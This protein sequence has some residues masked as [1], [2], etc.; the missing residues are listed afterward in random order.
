MCLFTDCS[1]GI[2]TFKSSKEWINHEFQ[3]HRFTSQWEC[4]LCKRT[5]KFDSPVGLQS[6]LAHS[7]PRSVQPSELNE[8][9]SMSK[10][11]TPRDANMERCPF[12]DSFQAQNRNQ[13]QNHVGGHLLKVSLACIPSTDQDE[14]DES[15]SSHSSLESDSQ[16]SSP[17]DSSRPSKPTTETVERWL[18]NQ[19]FQS[20][21]E[22][23]PGSNNHFLPCDILEGRLLRRF[24]VRMFL[25]AQGIP[26][27]E[28]L[29]FYAKT[30]STQCK[31]LLALLIIGAF[32]PIAQR[33]I[34]FVKRGITDI[35][36]PFH[37]YPLGNRQSYMLCSE[38]HMKSG[39]HPC[40]VEAMKDWE[41]QEIKEFCRLQWVVQAPL[42]QKKDRID[43]SARHYEFDQSVVLPFI[44]TYE[45]ESSYSHQGGYSQVWPVRMAP[46]HQD[47]Y[48][49]A[50]L[51]VR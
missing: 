6:H 28:E 2:R 29:K 18:V 16:K 51:K 45:Y 7:H 36:L 32:K 27:G 12:C 34:E 46:G 38:R 15:S 39:A 5:K 21:I 24:T 9:I 48:L 42:F 17:P 11:T 50:D 4:S 37:R 8:M 30:I 10:T 22:S 31:R 14:G 49:P 13:F 19:L 35:D 44:E 25:V 47:I 40:A 3:E 33:L 43:G 20:Q 23:P 26:E 1:L 41:I